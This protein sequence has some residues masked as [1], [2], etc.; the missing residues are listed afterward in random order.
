MRFAP[1]KLR[2]FRAVRSLTLAVPIQEIARGEA[3]VRNSKSISARKE[4]VIYFFRFGEW[5][6]GVGL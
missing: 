5:Q 6:A 2:R 3:G 4:S 1:R